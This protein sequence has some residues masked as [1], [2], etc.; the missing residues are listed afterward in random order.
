ME[1]ILIAGHVLVCCAII[2]LI[3]LQQGKGA[4]MGASFGSGASQTIFGA[5][6]SG[7]IL[8]HT[9]AW[10]VA[11]FFV[12]SIGLAIVTKN[13]ASLQVDVGVPSADVIEAVEKS[14]VPDRIVVN[15]DSDIPVL[16]KAIQSDIPSDSPVEENQ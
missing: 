12:S 4:E 9:T 3:L 6:G 8:S 11:V 16:N 10:L 15:D 5:A 7:N 2:G 13:R 1:Q 14:S